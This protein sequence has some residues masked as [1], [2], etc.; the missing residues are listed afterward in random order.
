MIDV[1]DIKGWEKGGALAGR[2]V[3]KVIATDPDTGE[4]LHIKIS[5]PTRYQSTT[6]TVALQKPGEAFPSEYIAQ[7]LE[8][9]TEANIKALKYAQ[10]N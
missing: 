4:V 5:G 9:E 7:G 2:D 10:E 8:D 6:Y 3:H 1:S